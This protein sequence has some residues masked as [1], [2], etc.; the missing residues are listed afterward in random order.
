MV[1]FL[2]HKKKISEGFHKVHGNVPP[3]SNISL[4]KVITRLLTLPLLTVAELHIKP[5]VSHKS[6]PLLG[7]QINLFLLTGT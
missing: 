1:H 2:G 6:E 5:Y 4:L 7:R 3:N